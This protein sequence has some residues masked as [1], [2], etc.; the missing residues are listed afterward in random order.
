VPAG[1]HCR[2]GLGFFSPVGNLYLNEIYRESGRKVIDLDFGPG[3]RF[4][5][6][7]PSFFNPT[8]YPFSDWTTARTGAVQV[9]I[10]TQAGRAP[11]IAARAR[12]RA[13][14]SLPRLQDGWENLLYLGLGQP[15]PQNDPRTLLGY[16]SIWMR[17]VWPV[18]FAFVALGALQQRFRGADW[19]LPASALGMLALLSVQQQGVMEARF[20]MPVDPIFLAALAV[21][22]HRT[23][24]AR[25]RAGAA[26]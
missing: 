1:L 15:W 12:A 9:S 3:G 11:W 5:F 21:M 14:R 16:C 24:S 23:R 17:W 22:W 26:D 20:R 10:D 18:L 7:S 2:A 4:E 13:E 6:G 19:L 25:P 8:F